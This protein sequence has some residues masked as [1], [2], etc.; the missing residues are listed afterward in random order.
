MEKLNVNVKKLN[1]R[2]L[3]PTTLPDSNN[4]AGI[5]FQNYSFEGEEITA[6]PNPSIGKWF[7]DKEGYFYWG[8]GLNV[9]GTVEDQPAEESLQINVTESPVAN[10]PSTIGEVA[11]HPSITP[12]LKSRIQQA[13]NAFETG[14]AQGDYSEVVCY[15]DY[16][17]PVAGTFSVQVT[18]GR[19]QTTEFGNLKD[20]IQ[21]YV[22]ANG[23]YAV[24]LKAYLN[25][26]GIP[27]SLA[28]D[29]AFQQALIDAGK[30]DPIMKTCQDAFFDKEYYSPANT[31]F[32]THGF[33]L[34]LSMLVIYD[35]HVHSGG[36]LSFLRRKFTTATPAAGGNEKEWINN[37]V[38]VRQSWLANN[39]NPLLR[40]TVYR[41]HCFQQQMFN[42]NWDLAQPFFA[43]GIRI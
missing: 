34:P 24:Q 9:L 17:D 11:P 4:I 8:G 12:E 32:V 10:E 21:E 16:K 13:V 2:S 37:Y 27:P 23:V 19:S 40:K 28:A 7:K 29:K 41:T 26:I 33:S 14:S 30:Q 39:A 36:I 43:N 35:S 6:V 15:K 20:L 22:N 42:N 1:K 31:W 38:E 5:V 18:Y 25:R 3:I